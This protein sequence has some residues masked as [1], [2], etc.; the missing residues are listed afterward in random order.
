[1]AVASVAVGSQVDS[2]W[3]RRL[4]VDEAVRD[5][6]RGNSFGTTQ[7]ARDASDVLL[8]MNL[9]YP[10]IG[11]ALINAAWYRQSPEVGR[12]MALV[13]T[14]ALAITV[15]IQQGVANLT[16]RERPYGRDCGTEE[17]PERYSACLLHDRYRSYFSGHTSLSFTAAALTCTHH[18]H[19]PL[20]GGRFEWLPCV[21]G[22]SSATATGALR[23]AGDRHYFTDVI[24]GALVGGMVGWLVPTWHYHRRLRSGAGPGQGAPVT[25]VPTPRG[26]ILQGVF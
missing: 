9:S 24:T 8:S 17:L 13:D 5:V 23:I 18:A 19:L 14:E 7:V 11:D 16:G 1:M 25:L 20:H 4:G 10:Y 21:L 26:F 12:E 2:L 6:V 3:D 22:V 15:A